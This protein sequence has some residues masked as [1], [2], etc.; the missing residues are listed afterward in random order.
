MLEVLTVVELL[1][2][3]ASELEEIF[4][5]RGLALLCSDD[6]VV[7]GDCL[8]RPLRL[9]SDSELGDLPRLR[10]GIVDAIEDE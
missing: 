1:C 5:P 7:V 6:S 8:R 2:V 3:V 9:S 4:R 10:R